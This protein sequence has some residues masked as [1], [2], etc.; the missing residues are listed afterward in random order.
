[1]QAR[2][3]L[4]CLGALFEHYQ[5]LHATSNLVHLHFLFWWPNS[6]MTPSVRNVP[7]RTFS[8]FL[9]NLRIESSSFSILVTKLSECSFYEKPAVHARFGLACA[10]ARSKYF[11][12]F[13]A[14]LELVHLHFLFWWP[15]SQITPSPSNFVR[16]ADTHKIFSSFHSPILTWNIIYMKIVNID[17]FEVPRTV[18][19]I[20]I[21]VFCCLKLL[22]KELFIL[23]VKYWVAW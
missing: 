2:F 7:C 18:I 23:H 12:T 20:R 13:R 15:S 22:E 3:G 4:A 19:W 16:H 11:Q 5:T 17:Y 6:Q 8:I 21:N 9:C 14:T 10:P 1:M